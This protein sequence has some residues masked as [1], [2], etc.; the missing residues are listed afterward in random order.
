MLLARPSRSRFLLC[1]V[2]CGLAFFLCSYQVHEKHIL[3]PLLPASLLA[4]RQ[5]A[6][7]A[8]LATT[9]AFSLYPLLQRDGLSLPYALCQLAYLLL[10]RSPLC[11][12]ADSCGDAGSAS[13]PSQPG[14][15][16]CAL[17]L[18]RM[19]SVAE[20][21]SL[22]GMLALHVLEAT[23][24]PPTRYPDLHSVAFAAYSCVHFGAA[25]LLVVGLLLRSAWASDGRHEHTPMDGGAERGAERDA[26]WR[27]VFE[28]VEGQQAQPRPKR[29]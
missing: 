24:P 2:A 7:F 13:A 8:W 1:A 18:P 28:G 21:L 23:V 22:C 20:A 9:A 10:A 14:E 29:A 26:P 3:L 25:Y 15:G 4:H 11:Q 19:V 5:P 12:P 16:R 17:Q 27:L 6:L